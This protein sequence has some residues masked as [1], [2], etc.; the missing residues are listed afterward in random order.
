MKTNIIFLCCIA[1]FACSGKRNVIIPS[2]V[3]QEQ[4]MA[5]VMTDIH[6]LEAALGTNFLEF[7]S[8]KQVAKKN[9]TI[10][11]SVKDQKDNLILEL[12]KKNNVSPEEYK[13]SFV[14]YTAHPELLN[15]IYK[16]VINNLSELQAKVAVEKD[17]SLDS[18]VVKRP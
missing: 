3:L 4:K 18:V 5:A 10:T 2:T 16:L 11:L 8:K 14:F 13:R 7:K 6:L 15:E 9:D 1:L 17:V 12:F